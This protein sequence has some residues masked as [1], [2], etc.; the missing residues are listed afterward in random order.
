MKDSDEMNGW[1]IYNAFLKSDKFIDFANMLADAAK[2]KGHDIKIKTNQDLHLIL[3]SPTPLQQ[4]PDYVIFLDKDIYLAQALETKGIPVFNSAKAIEISDDKI[5]TYQRL[6]L[7]QIPFPK[8]YVLPKT[9]GQ[10]INDTSV[11][12]D[13]ILKSFS[14]PLIIKEAFGSFG[15]QV[16]LIKDDKALLKKI[17]QISD[18]PAMVQDFIHTS[19]G[20]D[21]RVQIVGD[22]VVAAMKR[23]SESDFRANITSGGKM[24]RHQVTKAEATLAIAASQAIG[25]DFSGVD[26]LLGDQD[27]PLVCEVN[28]N[29]HIRNLLDCTGINAAHDIIKYIEA[30]INEGFKNA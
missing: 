16:Y 18:K 9:F 6:A 21:I 12:I 7:K 28:S 20:S 23:T 13:Y 24:T 25:A 14:F 4:S 30:R 26:L 5:K 19:Y 15:E 11:I 22:K 8:T 1:I 17:I 29:A 27:T 2:Q 10:T 3:N